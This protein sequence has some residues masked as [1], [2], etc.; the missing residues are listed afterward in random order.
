[1]EILPLAA[2]LLPEQAVA[3]AVGEVV[4]LP[5]PPKTELADMAEVAEE[6]AGVDQV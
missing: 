6:K 3:V 2:M 4:V 5:L 1:M